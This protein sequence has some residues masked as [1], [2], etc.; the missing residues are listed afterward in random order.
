MDA[1]PPTSV[2]TYSLKCLYCVNLFFSYPMQIT[3]AI[4]ILESFIWPNN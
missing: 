2:A 1:L 3:P 4:D